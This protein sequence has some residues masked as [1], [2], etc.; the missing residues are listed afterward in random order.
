MP[1]WRGSAPVSEDDRGSRRNPAP[2]DPK[3]GPV[4]RLIMNRL[5][6]HARHPMTRPRLATLGAGCVIVLAASPGRI[7]M[8]WA[9]AMAADDSAAV[10]KAPTPIKPRLSLRPD[11]GFYDNAWA[12]DS[13]GKHLAV[14]H[15]D[16]DD[17][18]R[19]EIFDIEA[20]QTTPASSFDLNPA[21]RAFEAVSFLPD[22]VGL[23]LVSGG[24]NDAHV[25]EA[26][27][28][29]GKSLGRTHP[30]S[31]FGT[32][33]R[34]GESILVTFE[35]RA[36]RAG[37]VSYVVAPWKLPVLKPAGKPRSYVVGADGALRIPPVVPIAFFDGFSKLLAQRPG[38]YD[39][40]KDARQPDGQSVLDLLSGKTLSDSPID[41]VYGWARTTRLRR[42][43]PNRTAFIQ[44]AD[45]LGGQ[46]SGQTGVELVDPAGR[47]NPLRLAVPF[48]LYDRF[49]LKDQEGP[50]SGLIHFGIQV[51][52][53]NPDAV[54]RKKADQP[55][56]DVYSVPMAH[57]ESTRLVARVAMDAQPVVWTVAGDRL[58]ILRRYKSF[59]RGGDRIDVYDLNN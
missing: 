2:L 48:R 30:V 38:W 27:D 59:A 19:M 12:L 18:Q 3:P 55:A 44:L 15:T 11:R 43:H 58:V 40:K 46:I 36:G 23:L 26:I 14:I 45:A 53:V 10:D 6:I 29:T 49:T 7:G 13:T 21:A 32:T 5:A 25:V 37:E 9:S 50:A 52:P 16:R 54:A 22:A 42:E 17:F 35:R 31:E 39:K 51:D 8:P 28:K 33:T 41:D 57:P 1:I 34:G 4:C 20:S 24:A 56:L 47:L